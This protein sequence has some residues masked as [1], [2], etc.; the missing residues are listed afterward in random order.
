MSLRCNSHGTETSS[1]DVH[2]HLFRRRGQIRGSQS[3]QLAID[4]DIV[5]PGEMILSRDLEDTVRRRAA[6]SNQAPSPSNGDGGSIT[7]NLNGAVSPS[8]LKR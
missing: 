7:I 8:E 6:N 3:G 4:M 5:H 2:S 1:T